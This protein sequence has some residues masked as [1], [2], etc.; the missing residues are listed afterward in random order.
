MWGLLLCGGWLLAAGYL[1]GAM[2]GCWHQCCPG[3]NNACWAPGARRARC[4]CDSYCE[5]T[6]DCCEDY[7]AVCRRAGEYWDGMAPAGWGAPGLGMPAWAAACGGKCLLLS[8]SPILR[9][10]TGG[11]WGCQLGWIWSNIPIF[12]F[13][14][15]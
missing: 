1:V 15:R 12:C 14:P 8:V 11:V 7:H 10:V 9:V 5:R 13:F 3:R 4:Y 2:G 6:G